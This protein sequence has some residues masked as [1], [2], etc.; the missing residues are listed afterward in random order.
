MSEY[1]EI[2]LH[3]IACQNLCVARCPICDLPFCKKE[4][5]DSPRHRKH[6]AKISELEKKS[7]LKTNM[8]GYQCPIVLKTPIVFLPVFSRMH[9]PNVFPKIDWINWTDKSR[10]KVE[11]THE[12]VMI[13]L[14]IFIPLWMLY[15][16]NEDK[17]TIC[18]L[19][20]KGRGVVL[21]AM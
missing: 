17:D 11:T 6:C 15:F 20:N 3:C 8:G 2:P 16:T 4:C 19:M 1:T 9:I 12:T 13:R 14:D 18:E 10:I 21:K 5:T 7:F